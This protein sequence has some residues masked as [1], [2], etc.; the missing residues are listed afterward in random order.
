MPQDQHLQDL[1]L[2]LIDDEEIIHRSVGAFLEKMG[3]NVAHAFDGEEGLELFFH[4]GADIIISDISMPWLDGIGL[5]DRLQA[6]GADVEVILITGN[7]DT[8]AA[9]AALRHGAFDFFDKPVKLP[10]LIA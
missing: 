3:C 2:L 7:S 9:I 5:L 10:E 1:N 4:S 8:E 6:Q